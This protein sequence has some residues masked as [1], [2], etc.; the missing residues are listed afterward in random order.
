MFLFGPPPALASPR[1]TPLSRRRLLRT[2]GAGAGVL[3]ITGTV[4]ACG[5]GSG[6]A[7]DAPLVIVPCYPLEYIAQHVGADVAEVQ[8]LIPPGSNSHDLE[9][10]LAQVALLEKATLILQVPGMIAALD[11]TIASRGLSDRSLDVSTVIPLLT[12][13]GEEA[14]GDEHAE[15]AHEEGAGHE[16][17]SGHEGHEGHDHG[18]LDPHF[19]HDPLR[20]ATVG[21]AIADRL[22]AAIEGADGSALAAAADAARAELEA[23]DAELAAQYGA[24]SLPDGE[25]AFVTSHAAFGYLAQRYGLEQIGI[26]G[27]DPEV[28][29]SPNRLLQLEQII[30][31]KGL[32][33]V[34]FE[35][36]ASPKVAESLAANIGVRT[37][38][39]DN[40]ESRTS[41]DADYPAVMRENA[42]RIVESWT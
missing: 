21:D 7:S 39:L 12:S 33:T 35:T 25:R 16:E 31:D 13:T 22:G 24:S 27:I 8:S 42:R 40:L 41:E 36:T 19:W 26:S 18:A 2:L 6:A 17:E 5:T 15:D 3:A 28:E 23:L 1:S 14:H 37:D 20:L 32:T 30:A 4:S 34:F 9:L 38:E 10:S 11:D 29:P